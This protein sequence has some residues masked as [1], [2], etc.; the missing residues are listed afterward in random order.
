MLVVKN[1]PA[2][3]GDIRDTGLN[4]G[5]GR[6]LGGRHGNPL[7]YSC[8]ENPT[9]RGAWWVTIHRVTKSRTRMKPFITH[10]QCDLYGQLFGL[11]WDVLCG[12]CSIWA[13]LRK[14]WTSVTHQGRLF[15]EK[16]VENLWRPGTLWEWQVVGFSWNPGCFWRCYGKAGTLQLRVLAGI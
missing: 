2:N 8:L 14:S 11:C 13:S 9:D 16:L 15:K 1:L 7:Q 4:P 5:F 3:A 6:S 10:A 12:N